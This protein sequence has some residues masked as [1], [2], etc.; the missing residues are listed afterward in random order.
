MLFFKYFLVSPKDRKIVIV[1][2]SLC[3]TII[4]ETFTKALF[5][6]F[7]VSSVFFVP[8]HLSVL[9]TL[10]V[11]TALVV[12]LGYSEGTVL[13]IY[14]GTQ[15]LKAFQAENCGAQIIHKEIK[16]QL[17]ES[18]VSEHL[19]TEKV[20]EDIKARTCFVTTFERAEQL[21]RGESVQHPPDIDYPV[22]EKTVIV[23]PGKLRETAFEVLFSIESNL[24]QMILNSLTYCSIEVRQELAENLVVVGGTAMVMGL[25]PRL[26]S[27][28]LQDIKFSPYA[29]KLLLSTFKI[30][31]TIG[32]ANFTSWLGGSIYGG[33]DLIITKSLTKEQYSKISR[34]P[35]WIN[36]E[37]NCAPA[38]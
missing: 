37:D 31:K 22:K 25:L 5:R 33:T 20:L 18:G 21:R 17:M 3:P 9:S 2:S 13:P 26:Q 1:E 29:E 14:S 19:L 23:I 35:D 16:R 24:S 34:V 7:E 11:E 10:A 8:L 36:L 4:R 28:L 12:D 27:E 6:H 38:S 30:H 32:K 15:I